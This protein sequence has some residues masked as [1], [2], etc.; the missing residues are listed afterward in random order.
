MTPGEFGV[1]QDVLTHFQ[2]ATTQWLREL[3]AVG[4]H[5]FWMV[6][7]IEIVLLGITNAL[8]REWEYL[9]IDLARA[10]GGIGAMYLL[11]QNGPDWLQHGLIASFALWGGMTGGVPAAAMDPGSV[12]QQG[13]ALAE[14]LLRAVANGSWLHMAANMTVTILCGI[15]VIICFALVGI[16]LLETLIEGYI[17]CTGGTVL[18]ATSGSRFTHRFAERYFGWALGIAI[19]LFFLYLILGLGYALAQNWTGFAESHSTEIISNIYFPVEAVIEALILLILVGKIPNHAAQMVES[20]V[21]LTLGDIV[22]GNLISSSVRNGI[23]AAAGAGVSFLTGAQTTA[24]TVGG[25][26]KDRFQQ[27]RQ[28]LMNTIPNGHDGNHSAKPTQP[29]QPGDFG[30]QTQPLNGRGRG[31]RP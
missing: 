16:I 23:G 25:A 3:Y 15:V 31:G 6:A 1:F 21:S 28:A 30:Q 7:A 18:A 27:L 22:L 10:V 13:F 11:L 12:M 5:L 26:A 2:L 4:I 17:A 14:V 8:R 24:A 19:R 20:T 29:L 9:L